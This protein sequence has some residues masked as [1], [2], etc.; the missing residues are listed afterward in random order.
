MRNAIHLAVVVYL[1]V[2][3]FVAFAEAQAEKNEDDIVVRDLKLLEGKWE[4]LHGE[5]G[6]GALRSIKEIKGNRE[7]LR[8]YD[9]NTGKLI[10]EHEVEFKLSRSGEIRVFTFYPIDGDPQQG[11]SFIYKVDAENF[12]DVTGLLQGE[13]Y[14]NYQ[15]SPRVWHWK[16]VKEGA[17]TARVKPK[18][19]ARAE[20]EPGLLRKLEARRIRVSA[21]PDGYNIDV[22]RSVEFTDK[23]IELIIQ[24]PQVVELTM[25]AVSITDQGLEKLRALKVVRRLILNDCPISSK[26][27]E[28]LADLPLRE[29][30]TSLGLRGTKIKD[31][32]LSWI[33]NF[34]CLERLDV[35][36]TRLTDASLAALGSQK[37]KV[38]TVNNARFSPAALAQFQ[39]ENPTVVLN[40]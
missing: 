26:G 17:E 20:I 4:L 35:S 37:L 15:E 12:Y 33:K 11:Q 13:T 18:L 5:S 39:K 6:S 24:C 3:S 32:D 9:A 14:R 25:E 23:E 40:R 34:T 30:V 8:R 1:G 38:L 22:R 21:M 19:P 27:L 28:I 31:G 2:F 10:R 36:G 16:K 29:T 7:T